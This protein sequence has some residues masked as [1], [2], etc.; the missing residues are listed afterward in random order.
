[1]DLVKEDII[2]KEGAVS[3]YGGDIE[4][5]WAPEWFRNED[6]LAFFS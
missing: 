2:P 5:S 1:V 4:V 6:S 3:D